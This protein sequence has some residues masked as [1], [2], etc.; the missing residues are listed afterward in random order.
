[1]TAARCQACGGPIPDRDRTR[2]GRTARYCS[3]AC[4]ARAYRSRQNDS[5]L[6]GIRPAPAPLTAAA[7]HARVMEIRQQ[8]AEL[9][10]SLADTASGQQALFAATGPTRR[11][12][13]AD[14]A[15][16]LH[17]LITELSA[18]AEDATVTKRVTLRRTPAESAPTAPMFGLSP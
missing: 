15:R 11:A 18:L 2:G 3:G 13:P 16:K 5:Q 7:R 12:R 6:P 14:T 17:Q 8:L 4:K 1:V 9:T 10:G